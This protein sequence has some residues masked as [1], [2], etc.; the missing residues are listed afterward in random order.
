M[1]L[2][3]DANILFSCLIKEGINRKLLLESE[4]AFYTPSEVVEEFLEHLE[5]IAG[6]AKVNARL[7]KG[8]FKELLRMSHLKVV[9]WEEFEDYEGRAEKISP[10]SD[11]IPYFALALKLNCGIWSNDKLLKRQ[12][13]VMIYTTEE[14]VDG[15]GK[16]RF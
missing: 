11:D 12:K 7:L 14:L 15:I 8:K 16:G 6:K 5:E 10:D 1:K 13:K 2:V 4:F 9:S 3:V